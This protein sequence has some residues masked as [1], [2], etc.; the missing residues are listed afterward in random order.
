MK[1]RW[2]FVPSGPRQAVDCGFLFMVSR[3]QD[4]KSHP[5]SFNLANLA[6][7][8]PNSMDYLNWI[9]D[10]YHTNN[11]QFSINYHNATHSERFHGDALY[12]LGQWGIRHYRHQRDLRFRVHDKRVTVVQFNY[13][14][15]RRVDV[16]QGVI[17]IEKN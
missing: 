12:S 8:S 17:R 2:G 16:S 10:P 11:R 3:E 4:M 13:L 14:L 9:L 1:I 7:S 15:I 6:E 5:T